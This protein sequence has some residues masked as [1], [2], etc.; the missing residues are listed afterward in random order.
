MLAGRNKNK[1]A[2]KTAPLYRGARNDM[3]KASA[4][5]KE[6]KTGVITDLPAGI[7]GES[8]DLHSVRG[9]TR[10]RS[11]ALMGAKTFSVAGTAG[12]LDRQALTHEFGSIFDFSPI[13]ISQGNNGCGILRQESR[14]GIRRDGGQEESKT[15]GKL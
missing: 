8:S 14:S 6:R 9:A 5:C 12:E 11:C 10:A 1:M 4:R 3:M 13:F 7:I 2:G 15:Y